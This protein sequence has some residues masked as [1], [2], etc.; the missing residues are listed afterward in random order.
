MRS[1]LTISIPEEK[2]KEI[3][4]RA[5]KAGKSVSAYIIS[6]LD[7][8]STLITED[9]ILAMAKEADREYDA[10]KTKVLKSLKDLMDDSE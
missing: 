7:Y 5:K 6:I 4:R 2:K 1:V 3:E 10:G 8:Q 9:E